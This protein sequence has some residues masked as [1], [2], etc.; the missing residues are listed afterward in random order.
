MTVKIVSIPDKAETFLFIIKKKKANKTLISVN[1]VPKAFQRFTQSLRFIIN[2]LSTYQVHVLSSNRR[3]KERRFNFIRTL[4]NRAPRTIFHRKYYGLSYNRAF[5]FQD[6]FP[7]KKGRFIS[8][9]Q[10]MI[11]YIRGRVFF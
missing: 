8:V 11:S 3:L 6:T 5:N 2:D 9:L 10:Y 7:T 1:F 4:V